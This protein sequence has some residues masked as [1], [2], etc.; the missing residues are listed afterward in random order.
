MAE[1][2]A[3]IKARNQSLVAEIRR[4]VYELRPPALDEL[5]L[6]G[7]LRAAAS[8]P[9]A[10]PAIRISATPEPLPALPAAVEVAAY[11]IALEALTNAVRHARAR[12]C[13]LRLEL[14]VDGI[15]GLRIT[16]A[17]DGRGIDPDAIAGVGLRSM[18]ERAEELGGSLMVTPAAEGGTLVRA[19]L[20]IAAPTEEERR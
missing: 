9:G 1:L 6:L 18:R 17:D 14:A 8:N 12:R 3:A 16:V 5:G 15:P 4:L 10:A 20:P 7:A 2:L 13:E 19:W 11:R